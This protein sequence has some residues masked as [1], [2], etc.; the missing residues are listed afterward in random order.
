[1]FYGVPIYTECHIL[2]TCGTWGTADDAI[3]FEM[4]KDTSKIGKTVHFELNWNETC[5]RASHVYPFFTFWTQPAHPEAKER[6]RCS[7]SCDSSLMKSCNLRGA[8][9][10]VSHTRLKSNG[11]AELHQHRCCHHHGI[12]LLHVIAS[13]CFYLFYF[14]SC[15]LL[16][17]LS[18]PS[19]FFP[20]FAYG[21]VSPFS[22][23]LHFLF[24]LFFTLLFCFLLPT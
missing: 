24:L 11:L 8:P 14:S 4:K 19:P 7:N 12:L 10:E 18:L 15:L 9:A 6:M 5:L 1:M 22:A 23:Q 20:V 13:Y 21:F 2:C 17:F 16:F 3:L